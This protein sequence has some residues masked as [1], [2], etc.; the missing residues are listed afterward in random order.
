[1]AGMDPSRLAR[2]AT[3][4]IAPPGCALCPAPCDPLEA[5]C[6]PC[7]SAIAASQAASA[8][9]PG[10]DEIHSAAVYEGVPR[11]LVSALK[12]SGRTAL[13][14]VAAAAIAG[15][16][17]GALFRGA[18]VP[19]PAA[20]AR[21]RR[22]GF[23]PATAIAEALAR[24]LGLPLVP[25]LRR[26]SGPRQ[27]G[28]PRSERLADPPRVKPSGRVP[29]ACVLVDDV[30]T[31]GATLGACAEALRGAGAERVAAVTFARTR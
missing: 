24:R 7:A 27:V 6:R 13:A 20:P 15:A 22:R 26:S 31:T 30:L 12:F 21:L 3:S 28:R 10:I 16:A 18:L 4:L 14:D 11:R 19:V 2:L 8:A 25:C 1:M 5:A 29:A 17:P 9:G 23:D